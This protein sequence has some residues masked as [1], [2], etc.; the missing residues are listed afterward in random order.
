MGKC[1]HP[2]LRADDAFTPAEW[3]E[4]HAAVSEQEFEKYPQRNRFAFLLSRQRADK[5][6]A[7]LLVR[8]TI[9]EFRFHDS[10]TYLR[11]LV[12]DVGRRSV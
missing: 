1:A 11:F 10:A 5:S 9:R 8:P 3:L 2:T 7:D 4:L 6:F 12:H